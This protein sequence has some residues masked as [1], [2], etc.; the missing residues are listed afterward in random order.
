MCATSCKLAILVAAVADHED[1]FGEITAEREHAVALERADRRVPP[2][3][4]VS[5][6]AGVGQ[7]TPYRP[8]IARP[9]QSRGHDEAV[10]KTRRI[11]LRRSQ[12]VWLVAIAAAGLTVGVLAGAWWG[13]G[14]AVLVLAISEVIERIQRSRT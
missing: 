13:V 3:R 4:G 9:E 7:A 14:A 2:T 12:I 10:A 1:E 11:H 5:G 6:P 8:G